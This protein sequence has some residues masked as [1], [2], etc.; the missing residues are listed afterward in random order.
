MSEKIYVGSGKVIETKYGDLMK[1]SLSKDDINTIASWMKE[2][3]ESWVNLNVSERRSP[4]DKGQTHSVTIDTWKP[5]SKK[6][7]GAQEEEDDLLP[8]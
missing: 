8:F 1:V 2:N 4:S 7:G 3:N 5:D 6:A